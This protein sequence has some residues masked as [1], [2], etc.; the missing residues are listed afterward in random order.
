M[1]YKLEDI[2]VENSTYGR[3]HLKRRLIGEG[4]LKYECFFNDCPTRQSLIWRNTVVVLQLDHINGVF[5]DNRLENLRFLCPNC[6]SQT[7]TFSGKNRKTKHV[8]DL[9]TCVCGRKTKTG[10]CQRCC[11]KVG[12]PKKIIWPPREELLDRLANS[13]YSKLSRELGISDNALRKHLL[14]RSE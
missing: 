6:H 9:I 1:K 3:S 5:N 4:I 12:P 13:N 10:K 7:E 14:T 8:K 2:L 11:K